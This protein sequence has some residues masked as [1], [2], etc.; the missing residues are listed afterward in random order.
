MIR[1]QKSKD[2]VRFYVYVPGSDG[3]RKYV[4]AFGSQKEAKAAEQDQ[5]STQRKIA[6][7]ELPPEMNTSRTFGEAVDEWLSS[8]DNRKSRSADGYR[9][10]VDLYLRPT[11]GP[12]QLSR[13]TMAHVMALRDDQAAKFAPATVNGTLTCLSSA[14]SYF[15]K[16]QWI[17]A[18]PC[19]GVEPIEN[20]ITAYNWIRTREE[21]TR[22]LGACAGDLRELVAMSLGTG[23]R[24]DELLHLQWA[25]VDLTRRLMTIH[26]GRQ[27]TVKSGKLRHV[28]ILDTVLPLLRERALRRGGAVLVFPGRKGAVRSKQGVSVIYK[29]ALKRAGMDAKTRWHDLRHT[30]A[31]HWMMDGG[32]IFRLSKVLGHSSVRITEQRYAHL[33]PEAYEQDYGRVSFVIPTEAAKIYSL[34]R[35]GAG[36]IVGRTKTSSAPGSSDAET[37]EGPG[38]IRAFGYKTGTTTDS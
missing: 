15:R 31:S 16:R 28:P 32:C 13:L 14:F 3:K 33:A 18:N 37:P 4:G 20:P 30:F 21:M 6:S 23:L 9:T 34:Q 19:Q 27:G 29:L 24:F 8:L 26:R 11:L 2:G 35:D 7:G 12:V 38:S 17:L 36:K 10:R 25:D 1:K 22:L 5:A